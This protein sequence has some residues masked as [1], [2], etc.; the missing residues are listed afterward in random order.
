M[1]HG[2]RSPAFPW[3]VFCHI[4]PASASWQNRCRSLPLV[5]TLLWVSG[6]SPSRLSNCHT[7]SRVSSASTSYNAVRSHHCL[8]E[9]LLMI[10]TYVS[11]AQY[12]FQFQM[13]CPRWILNP[14]YIRMPHR[15]FR[16]SV[17]QCSLWLE[18][19][20]RCHRNIFR[21]HAVP[22][23]TVPRFFPKLYPKSHIRYHA[24]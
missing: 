1:Y 12:F 14:H 7:G 21:F 6:W 13:E 9:K 16:A 20:D 2:Q 4:P 18:V 11:P 8:P 23:Q 5:H 19:P 3:P 17:R 22:A 10:W 15:S 24:L